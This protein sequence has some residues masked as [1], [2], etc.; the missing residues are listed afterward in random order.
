MSQRRVHVLLST[1]NG[2][3]HVEEQLDS[4][5]RQRAVEVRVTIRDDGST[6][7]TADLVERLVSGRQA[8]VVRGRNL[9]P[10]ASFLALLDTVEPDDDY[11]AFCDQDD[12][13]APT[14]LVRA[15]DALDGRER[16]T[17]YCARIEV[18]DEHLRSLGLHSLPRRGPSFENALVQNVATGATIV[19]NRSA[20]ALLREAPPRHTVMH[21]SWCYL[22]MSGCGDV[23][24]DAHPVMAY[25]QHAA[26]AVGVEQRPLRQWVGR[27]RRQWAEGHLQAH[28]RQNRELQRCY[29][30]RVDPAR[31]RQLAEYLRAADGPLMVR[32][33]YVLTGGAHRQDV[34]SDLVYRVLFVLCRV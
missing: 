3:R 27:A 29:G 11:V 12:V 20:A 1:W 21:D 18:V 34:L 19:L 24:Y 13:W 10:A 32:L 5:W 25:R 23:I 6:D 14:K 8:R 33:Q 31:R 26:N 28:T 2:R 15:L 17:L 4:I 30:S 22:V 9:G 16:A 7:G